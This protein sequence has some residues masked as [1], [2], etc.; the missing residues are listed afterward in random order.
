MRI[1]N[2]IIDKLHA[3]VAKVREDLHEVKEK[4]E[5][6]IAEHFDIPADRLEARLD[7][8]AANDPQKLKWRTS[9]VDFLKLLDLDSSIAIRKEMAGE[10]G[11]HVYVGSADDNIWLH[12]EVFQALIKRGIPL[13]RD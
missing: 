2:L 5:E 13:P 8:L 10:L 12:G 7:E 9:I 6:Q 3:I 1:L 4:I 11:N